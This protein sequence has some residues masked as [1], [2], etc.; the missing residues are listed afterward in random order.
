MK[1]TLFALLVVAVACAA[2][3]SAAQP[4]PSMQR[5]LQAAFS[6][7]GYG[8]T[9]I[10]PDGGSVAW[11]ETTRPGGFAH[12]E[13]QMALYVQRGASAPVR[14]TA[15]DGHAFYD[16][17]DPVWSPDGHTIAFLSDARA[18]NQ[19][20]I[21]LANADASN[22]R[23][24]T[25]LTGAVQVLRWSPNGHWIAALSIAHPHRPSGATS[26]GARQVGVIGSVIDEQ[27]LAIVDVASGALRELTPSN[28]YVYEY[29]WSPGSDRLAY[30]YAYGS[31]DNNW[32]IARLATVTTT[33]RTRD[34]FRPSFQI[35]DPAWSPDGRA[36]ALIGG[37]MSDFGS[38]G[39]DVYLVNPVTG[40]A[41]DA[42]PGTKLSFAA[43][44]WTGRARMLALAHDLGSLEI[45]R[46]N[47]ANDSASVIGY[48]GETVLGLDV[49]PNGSRIAFV[50]T[51]FARPAEVWAG[52]PGHAV[53]LTR[54]SAAPPRFWSKAVSIRWTDGAYRPQGWLVYPLGFQPH[55]RY[56]LILE[57]HGGPSAESLPSYSNTYVAALTSHGYFVFLPNP[58]GSFGQGEAYTRANV[59]DFGYGDWRDD[60]TGVD[61]AIR[62]GYVDPKRLGVFG[63][64]YGGY[65]G[66]WA[67]TQTR[68][69][70]A[71]VAGAGVADWLSYYGQNDIDQWMI[72]FFGASVY[73]DPAVYARSSP[74]TFIKNSHTP[75]LILQGERD[76]EVPA[77][78]AFEFYHAMKTLGVP[79]Q[80]VVYAD[81][82]HGP[83]KPANQI[84]ALQR[85]VGW[86][87]RYLK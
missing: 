46:L 58:R 22:V 35:N 33:G 84:D 53:A 16:E 57:V 45:T 9:A 54:E 32:W 42:T 80:L 82:G 86:F 62:T 68:R 19:K 72:P 23:Q 12:P 83:R 27:R 26:V 56:P 87:D 65:M 39:G 2:T 85:T 59:K 61:A 41:R 40:R 18:K 3:G 49:T 15:G 69:F 47:L 43:L 70:R 74:I 5:V 17:S 13:P 50:R 55:K 31:G 11:Q 34:V 7:P 28:A 76:E 51:S 20:Q 78:Q 36:I 24:L 77:P 29:G 1:R 63:W 25:H 6:L 52:I 60:V 48:K 8:Q 75:I 71:I 14:L 67:E 30:T 73:D 64:S 79:T 37:I 44:H 81:E 38:V 10:S 21:F 66:M 4:Q